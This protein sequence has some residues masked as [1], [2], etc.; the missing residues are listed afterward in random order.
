MNTAGQRDLSAVAAYVAAVR[1]ALGD[2]PGDEVAEI[3]EDVR[4]HL[5]QVVTEFDEAVTAAALVARL[6]SPESYATELR[7]AADL[8]EP[9]PD[10]ERAGFTRRLLRFMVSVFAFLA[11]LLCTVA[12]AGV[13]L[14]GRDQGV[15]GVGA[16]GLVFAALAAIGVGLLVIGVVDHAAELRQVPGA[17]LVTSAAAW[18]RRQSWGEPTIAFIVSLQPAWWVARA[19]LTAWI[20]NGFLGGSVASGVI[21][22]VMAM[23]LSI[24]AG[25]RS[26]SGRFGG[27]AKYG[28]YAA[29]TAVVLA[30]APV[31]GFAVTSVSEPQY[32]EYVDGGYPGVFNDGIE[33][34][35]LFPY[36]PDGRLL[37]GVR[38]YDQDGR[39]FDAVPVYPCYDWNSAKE[40]VV[41][42]K[43]TNVFPREAVTQDPQTGECSE[44]ELV[45]PFGPALPGV[46]IPEPTPSEP[47]K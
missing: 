44:P 45:T 23:A 12:I 11:V 33:V 19:G 20:V 36:G 13:V 9:T 3:V 29:N 38:L 24:W 25:R 1:D 46:V 41:G 47:S 43:T 22:F 40:V 7:Q 34:T 26:A 6:G 16:T 17:R 8:P 37:E 31:A 32:V 30:V 2:L 27:W 28:T 42:T 35:N 39:P 5:E 21:V 15:A 10:P 4:E 18:V 14:V